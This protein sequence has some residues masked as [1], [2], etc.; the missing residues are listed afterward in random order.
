M[1]LL[2][3]QPQEHKQVGCRSIWVQTTIAGPEGHHLISPFPAITSAPWPPYRLVLAS[4]YAFEAHASSLQGI[5]SS[6]IKLRD[7]FY[8]RPMTALLLLSKCK[9]HASIRPAWIHRTNTDTPLAWAVSRSSIPPI[10]Y[11][12]GTRSG[13]EVVAGLNRAAS[14]SPTESILWSVTAVGPQWPFR[15][16]RYIAGRLSAPSRTLY[17]DDHP[18]AVGMNY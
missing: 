10:E 16:S 6:G 8:A 7:C 2:E 1:A 14:A 9:K 15:P 4:P 11:R 18:R 12:A 5:A 3:E 13:P 17:D